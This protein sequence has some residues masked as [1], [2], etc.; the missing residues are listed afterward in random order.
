[1]YLCRLSEACSESSGICDG[2]LVH[3]Y[4]VRSS[5][6]VYSRPRCVAHLIS[7]YTQEGFLFLSRPFFFFLHYISS[8]LS[9]LFCELRDGNIVSVSIEFFCFSRLS[10]CLQLQP[11]YNCRQLSILI[12][13]PPNPQEAW[14]LSLHRKN[15]MELC[16]RMCMLHLILPTPI[17]YYH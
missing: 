14:R 7:K 17:P 8:L 15:R 10:S 6:S 13:T 4:S 1:M 5:I 3:A 9:L 11:H 2:L 12:F 16:W